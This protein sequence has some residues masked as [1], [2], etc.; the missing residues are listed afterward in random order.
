LKN[1]EKVRYSNVPFGSPPGSGLVAPKRIASSRP[2]CGL[3]FGWNGTNDCVIANRGQA[4]AESPLYI[5]R[6]CVGYAARPSSATCCQIFADPAGL[7]CRFPAG[8]LY[9]ES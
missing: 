7:P 9:G 5:T 4:G 1:R 3:V 2:A 6:L 8:H